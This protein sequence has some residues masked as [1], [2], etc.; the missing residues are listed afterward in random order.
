MLR[1]DPVAPIRKRPRRVQRKIDQRVGMLRCRGASYTR[2]ARLT[3]ALGEA[4][5]QVLNAKV[6]AAMVRGPQ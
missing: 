6:A 5:A 3:R 2:F 1:H 4:A